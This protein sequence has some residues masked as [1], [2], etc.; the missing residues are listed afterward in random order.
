MDSIASGNVRAGLEGRAGARSVGR[1]LNLFLSSIR[2]HHPVGGALRL[3]SRTRPTDLPDAEQPCT[4]RRPCVRAWL[5][6][7][8]RDN[9]G[10]GR[11]RRVELRK[12]LR[13]EPNHSAGNPGE[14]EVSAGANEPSGLVEQGCEIGTGGRRAARFALMRVPLAPIGASRPKSDASRPGSAAVAGMAGISNLGCHRPPQSSRQEAGEALACT[15]RC[16]PRLG[17]MITFLQRGRLI[18]VRRNVEAAAVKRPLGDGI[19]P[20]GKR[21]PDT[22]LVATTECRST[23]LLLRSTA[24]GRGAPTII[25]NN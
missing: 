13:N 2:L 12:K 16:C 20:W 21:V 19:V 18:D 10:R 1:G 3:T 17:A 8:A 11:S 22:V 14:S 4:R 23:C 6:A 9:S 7:S 24:R 15:G 5:A 25:D